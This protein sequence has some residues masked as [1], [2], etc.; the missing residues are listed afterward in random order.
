VNT[1]RPQQLLQTI[2]N[3]DDIFYSKTFSQLSM[4]SKTYTL[5]GTKLEAYAFFVP[6]MNATD[7]LFNGFQPVGQFPRSVPEAGSLAAVRFSQATEIALWNWIDQRAAA[8]LTLP[9]IGAFIPSFDHNFSITWT[10]R[11]GKRTIE[12]TLGDEKV[13]DIEDSWTNYRKGN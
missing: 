11:L 6:K 9:G 5:Y 3:T 10:G 12:G 13:I 7:T 2:K 1:L 8:V 4:G